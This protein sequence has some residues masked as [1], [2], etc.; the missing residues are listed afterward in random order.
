MEIETDTNILCDDWPDISDITESVIE[1]LS[2]NLVFHEFS[3][4]TTE[5]SIVLAD[6]AFIRNLNKTYRGKDKPTNVLSFPQD[7]GSGDREANLGDVILAYETVKEEAD[8][9]GKG[10]ED[11][12]T[13][14]LVHGILH[15]LA[16]D[17]EDDAE[18][19][20]MESLEIRVL[21][22]LGIKN[23]YEDIVK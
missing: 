4:R 22:S 15:L 1:A 11:H 3:G 19:E 7:P 18:A 14:L 12:V 21:E 13:H 16:Y 20:E 2:Q 5:I 6:N 9:Q 17:H 8:S 10:F 23:P